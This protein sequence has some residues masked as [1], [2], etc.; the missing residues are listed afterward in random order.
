MFIRNGKALGSV[1]HSAV[2]KVAPPSDEPKE[3]A[4]VIPGPVSQP[5]PQPEKPAKATAKP[6]KSGS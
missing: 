5:K 3:Q 2:P 4:P 6:V 1:L